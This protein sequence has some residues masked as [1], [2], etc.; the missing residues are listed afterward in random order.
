MRNNEPFAVSAPQ[1]L[2]SVLQVAD[3]I[4]A[5]GNQRFSTAV[6]YLTQSTWSHASIYVGHAKNLSNLPDDTPAVIEADLENG[7]IAVPLSKY[8]DSI[9]AFADRLVSIKENAGKWCSLCWTAWE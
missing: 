1:I 7:V 2:E 5:E 8:T 3:V 4:L 9:P 6:K